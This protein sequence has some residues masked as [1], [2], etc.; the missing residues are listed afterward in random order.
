MSQANTLR[1]MAV[2]ADDLK[3][4]SA[5]C[6]DGVCKP[7]DIAYEARKRRFLIEF[8]RFRWENGEGDAQQRVRSALSLED[9][10]GVKARG[11]PPKSADLVLSL[12]SVEWEEGDEAPSGQFRLIFAGD[13]ELVVSAD[14]LDATLV[15]VSQPWPAKNRPA[16]K[17]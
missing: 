17:E 6:Q 1:L 7:A 14:C 5:A 11:L 2:D 16:H 9:V 4:I 10:T 13:G 12:M 15:D 8:N 3:I